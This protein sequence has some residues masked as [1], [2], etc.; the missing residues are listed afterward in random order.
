[1]SNENIHKDIAA[2]A[3]DINTLVP[4]EG[5]PRRGDVEAVK[6]SYLRFGQRK[7]ITANRQQDGRVVTAGNHQLQAAK[8]LGWT[9][10]AVVWTEDDEEDALAWA[11]ADNRVSDLAYNDPGDLFEILTSLNELDGTGYTSE[12]VDA[13]LNILQPTDLDALAEEVGEPKESDMHQVIRIVVPPTIYAIWKDKL[14]EYENDEVECIS[15]LL[16]A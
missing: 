12:D 15:S 4:L 13:M 5:N 8:E 2:L 6:A 7:P 10:I 9:K 14:K 11:V 1:M 16:G 3:V